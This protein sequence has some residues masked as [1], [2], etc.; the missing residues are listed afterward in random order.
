MKQKSEQMK[1]NK[2]LRRQKTSKQRIAEENDNIRREI[3]KI[4][5]NSECQVTQFF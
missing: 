1:M 3:L 4:K 2:S 5:F